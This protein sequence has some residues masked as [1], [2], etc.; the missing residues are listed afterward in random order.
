M[1]RNIFTRTLKSIIILLFV[2]GMGEVGWGQTIL[3]FP[4][5]ATNAPSEYTTGNDGCRVL[6][7]ASNN[8]A[9]STS[10]GAYVSGWDAGN[11]TKYWNLTSFNSNNLISLTVSF[12][13]RASS[14]TGPRDFALQYSLNNSTWNTVTALTYSTGLASTGNISLPATCSNQPNLYLRIIMTSNTSIANGTINSTAYTYLKGVV[15]QGQ[16]PTTPSQASNI[17][18]LAIT[19]TTIKVAC[20]S[21]NGTHRMIKIN[22]I[23]SWENPIDNFIPTTSNSSYSGS[24]EQT[25]YFGTNNTLTVT[26]PNAYT[27][28]HFRVFEYNYYPNDA[29]TKFNTNPAT[30]NPKQCLLEAIINPTHSNIRLTTVEL[31]AEITTDHSGTITERGIAWKLTP[32][33]TSTD[34]PT[35]EPTNQNGVFSLP[36][37][38]L[39]RSSTIYYIAF[40]SNA[41]GTSQT[42]ETTFNN[43]PRFTGTGTW[44]TADRWNVNPDIPGGTS[45][46]NGDASDKPVIDGTCTLT[47]DITCSDLTINATRRLNIDATGILTVSNQLTETSGTVNSL[48]VLSS[49]AGTGTLIHNN[50][51]VKGTIERYVSGTSNLYHMLSVP[52]KTSISPQVSNVFYWSYLARYSEPSNNWIQMNT[53][54]DSSLTTRLGYL[55]YDP[56]D[57]EET[58]TISGEFNYDAVSPIVTYQD[59]SG[60]NLVGNPY[61]S[62]I[63]WDA[64]YAGS[65]NIDGTIYMWDAAN[66]NYFT[67]NAETGQSSTGTHLTY[68]ATGQAFFVKA[69]AENPSLSIDPSVRTAN[70]IE[71]LKQAQ[72]TQ[73]LLR[74]TAT[75]NNFTDNVVVLFRNDATDLFDNKYDGYNLTSFSSNLVPDVYTVDAGGTKYSMNTMPYTGENKIIEMAFSSKS[76]GQVVLKATEMESFDALNPDLS[77]LLEDKHTGQYTSLKQLPEY[78]FA[79]TTTDD[80]NR[81]RIHFI[82]TVGISEKTKNISTYNVYSV[83]K[84]LYINMNDSK[85]QDGFAYIYDVQ[86]RLIQTIA[87]DRTGKQHEQI[88]AKPGVYMVKLVAARNT[89]THK[90]AIR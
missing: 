45:G 28:Y 39:P 79:Y 9:Y 71:F 37:E 7:T 15:L 66:N 88:K 81:F 26:V 73:D 60:W 78:S 77:I 20:S 54:T 4:L 82:N 40:V 38:L 48:H 5:T 29:V 41:A 68:I 83:N 89:E 24:G 62:P 3:N 56:Y 80:P 49:N 10:N 85:S 6:E 30:D 69:N 76:D 52:I 36:A 53:P 32:G 44:E 61:P 27:E 23:D 1:K 90:I 47:S 51:G 16:T 42:V 75:F 21:G 70:E 67:Y 46:F 13:Y 14:T 58:Y 86:G 57:P 11:G 18:F 72:T 65:T 55:T 74:I 25:L 8:V 64:T 19:P 35:L 12:F 33:V 2:L 59:G 31:G 17:T 50:A 63:D 87:L 34:N 43:I 22:T 84:E